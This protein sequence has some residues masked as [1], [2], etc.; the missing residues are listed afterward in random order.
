MS[1]GEIHYISEPHPVTGVTNSKLG[2]WLL[3]ASE[4]MLF[5]GLFSAYILIRNGVPNWPHGSSRLNVPLAMLN[6]FVLIS[7]SMTMV[8]SWASLMKKN[9]GAYRKYMG[10]TV[11]LGLVFLVIKGIEYATKF[12]HHHFPSTDNFYATYFVL[13]GL[14]GLHVIA[15]MI[16]NTYL[17]FPGLKMWEKNPE[18]FTGRIEAAGLYWHFVDLVWIFL[19]PTLYL[20]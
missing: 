20:L 19:F 14:H 5:G 7:S 16:V 6:T 10:A 8:M 1:L 3:I 4:I 2:V 9:V 15:G 17:L 11:L 12:H 18:Q 13:T